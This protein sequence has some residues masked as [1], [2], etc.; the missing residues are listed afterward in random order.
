MDFV[1]DD[2]IR[3]LGNIT[4]TKSLLYKRF[5]FLLD[6]NKQFIPLSSPLFVRNIV[7][8]TEN[9]ANNEVHIILNSEAIDDD[10]DNFAEFSEL[11]GLE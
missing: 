6:K 1:V 8:D 2:I 9:L 3:G 7:Y 11:T 4:H 10:P 5:I